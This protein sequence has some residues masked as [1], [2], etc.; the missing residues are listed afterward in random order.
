MDKCP[1]C[2]ANVDKS[3]KICTKCGASLKNLKS[4]KSSS[5]LMIG[6]IIAIILI[7]I[8]AVFA[9]G[10]LSGDNSQNT[11]ITNSSNAKLV[12]PT[13]SQNTSSNGNVFWASSKTDKFHK[14]DCEWAQKIS[15]DNKIVYNHREDAIRAGKTPCSVCNP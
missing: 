1:S 10:I 7:A 4:D 14:P 11:Q 9:S 3:D 15:D 12:N 6:V 2:G 5:K 13:D 8:V